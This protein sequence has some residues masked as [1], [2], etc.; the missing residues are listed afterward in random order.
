MKVLLVAQIYLPF[1]GGV[2]VHIHQLATALRERAHDAQVAAVNFAPT[3]L[4]YRLGVLHQ[5]LL[6]PR[7]E[8]YH[9]GSVP[10]HS[11]T[12]SPLDRLR[13]IPMVIRTVPRLQRIAYH[14]LNRSSYSFYKPVFGPRLRQLMRG[15]DLVHSFA[16]GH[17]GWTAQSVAAEMKIP[18]VCTPFVHPQQWGDGPDDVAYYRRADAVIGLVETDKQYLASLGVREDRLHV[19]GVSPNLPATTDPAGFRTRHGLGSS[20]VILYVGRMM[21]QKGAAASLAAAPLVWQSVPDARFIF[22]GP[23]NP[24]EAAQFQNCD[25][26]IKY[27]GKVSEQEKADA[28]SACD[29]FCMPSTSEILPTVYLEAWSYGKPVVGGTAHG[30]RELVEG[31]GAGLIAEQVPEQLAGI[32]LKMLENPGLR[33]QFG[34]RG[35]Q[36]VRDR[37]SVDA[38]TNSFCSLYAE[39]INARRPAELEHGCTGYT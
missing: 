1:V 35:R 26:R 25:P 27:L 30:L 21:A 8:S 34:E 15:A 5:S 18:F 29:I 38:V 4:P 6:A 10:V 31:N 3:N 11:L 17:L 28:L 39:L 33:A 13:L 12:P 20:P 22:I 7:F 36:L 14:G 24:A 2:E 19:I 16:F 32:L 37:Y 9:D 23:A